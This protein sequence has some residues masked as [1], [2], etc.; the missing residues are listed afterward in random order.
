MTQ[1]D[2]FPSQA[3]EYKSET[4]LKNKVPHRHSLKTSPKPR[5]IFIRF[6]NTQAP[7]LQKTSS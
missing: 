2:S 1:E 3:A 6:R 4:Q 7:V 5:V